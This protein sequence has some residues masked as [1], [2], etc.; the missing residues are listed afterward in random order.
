MV[1]LGQDALR[2]RRAD[3]FGRDGVGRLEDHQAGAARNGGRSPPLAVMG[4]RVDRSDVRRPGDAIG[5][6]LGP[7]GLVRGL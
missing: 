5:A 2:R 6:I 3:L 1:E 7:R 4:G